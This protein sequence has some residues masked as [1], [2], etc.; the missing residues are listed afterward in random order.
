MCNVF[1][2]LDAYQTTSI[3]F[4]FCL[5]VQDTYLNLI[6]PVA[7]RI[8]PVYTYLMQLLFLK[9]YFTTTY[10]RNAYFVHSLSFFLFFM[11]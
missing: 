6:N 4:C 8:Y 1:G 5:F 11:T 3:L 9:L 2:S 7:R 10:A